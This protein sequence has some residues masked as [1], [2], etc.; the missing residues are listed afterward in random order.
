[1]SA[2]ALALMQCL[3]AASGHK[4]KKYIYVD[5]DHDGKEEMMGS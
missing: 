2:E 3:E 5:M 1:M 4:M